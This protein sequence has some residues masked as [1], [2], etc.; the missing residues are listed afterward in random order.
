MGVKLNLV[1]SRSLGAEPR[2][3][4]QMRS[5]PKQRF[6][7]DAVDLVAKLSPKCVDRLSDGHGTLQCRFLENATSSLFVLFGP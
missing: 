6:V 7:A 4:N 1:K 2:P 5:T 3:G